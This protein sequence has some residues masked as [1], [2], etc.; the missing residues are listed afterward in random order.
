MDLRPFAC[1][2]AGLW[3]GCG[4]STTDASDTTRADPQATEAEPTPTPESETAPE[5]EPTPEPTPPTPD[6][7]AALR[8]ESTPTGTPEPAPPAD[9]S[10]SRECVVVHLGFDLRALP[11]NTSPSGVDMFVLHQAD[12][13]RRATPG[14]PPRFGHFPGTGVLYAFFDGGRGPAEVARCERAL[15]A[16][17]PTAPRLPIQMEPAVQVTEPCRPCE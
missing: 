11:T 10:A 4:S 6:S 12:E 1:V 15:A 14:A 7:H 8:P 16:Y 3:A 17:L 13:L 5:A 2:L 9:P